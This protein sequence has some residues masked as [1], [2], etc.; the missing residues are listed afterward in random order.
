MSYSIGRESEDKL[1]RFRTHQPDAVA[2]KEEL[3]Q[4]ES[5]KNRCID[6][7]V[8][9]FIDRDIHDESDVLPKCVMASVTTKLPIPQSIKYQ[10]PE[11]DTSQIK[12]ISQIYAGS[13]IDNESYWKKACLFEFQEDGMFRKAFGEEEGYRNI[14]QHG[15]RWK[16]FYFEKLLQIELEECD[17]SIMNYNYIAEL[18]DAVK[19]VIFTIRF[20][21]LPCHTD[22]I[23]VLLLKIPNLQRLNICY[24]M[25]Q[26]GMKY[27]R[28]E[29][30]IKFPDCASLSNYFE[31]AVNLTTLVLSKNIIDDDLLGV[32]I[33][34]L[35]RNRSVTHLDLSHN[36]ITLKGVQF[37]AKLLSNSSILSSLDLGNNMISKEGGKHLGLIIKENESLLTLN[38]RLNSL[39]DEGCMGVLDG[40]A[41]NSTLNTLNLSA[42]GAG[43]LAAEAMT[44]LLRTTRSD[45]RRLDMTNNNIG[46]AHIKDFLA[47]LSMRNNETLISFDLRYNP[48]CEHGTYFNTY[49][50]L[51]N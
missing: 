31:S 24:G 6:Y 36:K 39:D 19:D 48:G 18:I 40:V 25:N 9:T 1:R 21:Q 46:A 15:M 26:I 29:F 35:E 41:F 30:G 37:L 28:D 11:H 7:I 47:A 5:L 10:T 8:Q 50:Y 32:L 44:S 38:L 33:V 42:N 16:R 23:D 12:S 27:K 2:M 34:G 45:L 22:N 20:R 4:K 3:R 51:H 43:D 13:H 49:I 14:D 17:K